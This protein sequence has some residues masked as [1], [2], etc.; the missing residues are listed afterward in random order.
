M[1]FPVEAKG[2]KTELPH[3]TCQPN[4]QSPSFMRYFFMSAFELVST[5]AYGLSC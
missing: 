2:F 5:C 3:D 4:I 1:V